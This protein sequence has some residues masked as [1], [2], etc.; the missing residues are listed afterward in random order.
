MSVLTAS[1][2]AL[3]S[4]G[5]WRAWGG[6]KEGSPSE[7]LYSH[8]LWRDYSAPSRSHWLGPQWQCCGDEWLT[9]PASSLTSFQLGPLWLPFMRPGFALY[10][11]FAAPLCANASAN[12]QLRFPVSPRQR[13]RENT[14]LLNPSVAPL[15]HFFFFFTHGEELCASWRLDL[16]WDRRVF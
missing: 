16:K 15:H 4:A 13:G 8:F 3:A 10:A 1:L 12:S 7:M 9:C 14:S 11:L 5:I 6:E 2:P